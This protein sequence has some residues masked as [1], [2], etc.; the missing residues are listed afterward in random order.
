[1]LVGL[2]Q[3]ADSQLLDSLLGTV[4]GEQIC[5]LAILTTVVWYQYTYIGATSLVMY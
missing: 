1:M 5:V 3:Y 2:V 4:S